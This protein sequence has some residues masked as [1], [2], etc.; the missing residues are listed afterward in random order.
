VVTIAHKLLLPMIPA[1]AGLLI[2]RFGLA[3]KEAALIATIIIGK[4]PGIF[5]FLVWEL[6]EN[7][8]L[9]ATNRPA[10]LRPVVVGHHGETIAR[11]LR[12]GLHSGTLP[13]LFAKLRRADRKGDNKRSQRY[14]DALHHNEEAVRHFVEREF[15]AYLNSSPRWQCG[16]VSV[17]EV[18]LGTNG[19][20]VWLGCSSFEND[21]ALICWE[22]QSGWLLAGKLERRL[23]PEAFAV[24]D[25][26]WKGFCKTAGVDLL[27][28][29]IEGN[30][31]V[32]YDVSNGK[33]IVW[34]GDD[35]AIEAWYDLNDLP[36]M[37]PRPAERAGALPVLD[38]QQVQ[39]RLQSVT[40][41]EWVAAWGD[42]AAK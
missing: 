3:K 36:R 17:D 14:R 27:R 20:R 6:K 2:E 26:A 30:L 25:L 39:F 33:I 23:P 40:W 32:P 1:L 12:P 38:A 37:R 41:Q 24:I 7:W 29:Q 16:R 28:E 31:G 34:P 8:R 21:H 11:L 42:A 22:E 19:I 13:K 35:F 10:T 18:C 9:Y 4:I 5:G 15:A